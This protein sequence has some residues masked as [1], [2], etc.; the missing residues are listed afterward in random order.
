MNHVFR[1]HSARVLFA[2][3]ALG[4][5][6]ASAADVPS[7]LDDFSNDTQTSRGIPRIVVD[8]S[9]VGGASSLRQS[10][11]GG[12]LEATGDIAP[13][14]GQPGWVSLVL[15]LN[16]DGTPADLSRYEGVRL[17][18]RVKQGMLAVSASSSEITNFDYHSAVVPA[19]AGDLKEVRI[20]FQDMKRA[21]SE[22]TPL[23]RATITSISLVAVGF[24]K[25]SYAFE[26]DEIGFY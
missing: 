20:A 14:R 5:S 11:A 3:F 15:L 13:A 21:W 9:T 17:R 2:A 7:L 25:D 4:I 8:D 19:A 10:Y 22:P 1:F 12:L 24:Q 16:P 18:V 6:S 26:V 23:N